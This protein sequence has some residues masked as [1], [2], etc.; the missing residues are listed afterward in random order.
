[1]AVKN[2]KESVGNLCRV[3]LLHRYRISQALSGLNIYRGQPQLLGYMIDHGDCSQRD[4]VEFSGVSPACVATSIKRMSKAGFVE[5]TVDPDD[6]RIN[7]LRITE[8]GRN[9]LLL[10]KKECDRVDEMM[11]R[12]FT[13]DEIAKLSEMLGRMASNLSDEEVSFKEV[14]KY[15]EN[16]DK[17]DEADD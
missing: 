8:K 11:F 3:S 10:G 16:E 12:G 15:I 5:K 1:M 9:A 2:A 6:R 14:M 7:R 17:G 4:L 13:E